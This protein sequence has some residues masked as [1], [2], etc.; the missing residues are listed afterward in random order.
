MK[1]ILCIILFAVYTLCIIAWV[2]KD[3]KTLNKPA[4]EKDKIIAAILLVAGFIIANV[5]LFILG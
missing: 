1:E 4:T 3:R 2:Y 5:V